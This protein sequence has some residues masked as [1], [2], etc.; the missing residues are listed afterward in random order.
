LHF[1]KTYRVKFS[2]D[3]IH[4]LKAEPWHGNIRELKNFVA[5]AGAIMPGQTIECDSLNHLLESK[6]YPES[7]HT[8]GIKPSLLHEIEK[9][10]I[11]DSLVSHRGNQRKAAE[12]IG[13]PKSTF[14]DRT[15]YYGI[16]P[17]IFK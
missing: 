15:R 14:H 3:S 11:I 5:R 4:R 16:D 6:I 17:K 7:V 2:F 1:A 12:A 13:M 9:K 10:L 8:P